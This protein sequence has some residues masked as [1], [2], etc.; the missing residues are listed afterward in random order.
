MKASNKIKALLIMSVGAALV[1]CNGGSGTAT[2]TTSASDS[3][4]STTGAVFGDNLSVYDVDG[5]QYEVGQSDYLM[6]AI[7]TPSKASTKVNVTSSN[8]KVIGIQNPASCTITK[9]SNMCFVDFKAVSAG[10]ATITVSADGYKSYIADV[11]VYKDQGVDTATAIAKNSSFVLLGAGHRLY[12]YNYKTGQFTNPAAPFGGIG[13]VIVNMVKTNNGTLVAADNG[14]GV[15]ISSDDGLSWKDKEITNFNS[16]NGDAMNGKGNTLVYVG[17][18]HDD[19]MPDGKHTN[20]KQYINVSHDGGQTWQLKYIASWGDLYGKIW[21]THFFDIAISDNNHIVAT[22]E[23]GDRIMVSQN[24]GDSWTSVPVPNDYQM[25]TFRVVANQNTF[26]TA[27][28]KGAL[29]V[30]HDG[31][32]SW[33]NKTISGLGELDDIAIKGNTIVIVGEKGAILVSTDNGNTWGKAKSPTNQWL[34][35]V[36]LS[37]NTFVAVGNNGTIVTSTDGKTWKIVKSGVTSSLSRLAAV[38]NQLIATSDDGYVVTSSDG[39]KTWKST[40]I[41]YRYGIFGIVAY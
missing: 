28:W 41:D 13:G 20:T 34:A 17:N 31:G 7:Q 26:V 8:S 23:R 11:S 35:K 32:A 21:N 16:P 40:R 1:A 10:D 25:P 27:G 9:T 6:I 22:S 15:S 18:H 4:K 12:T 24:N 38:G 30:S 5:N 29:L 3:T 2:G 37:N 19:W 14:D 39:G 33:Q 36:V